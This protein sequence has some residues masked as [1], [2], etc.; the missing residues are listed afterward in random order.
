[1]KWWNQHCVSFLWFP[2]WLNSFQ[3]HLYSREGNF[4]PSW[5]LSGFGEPVLIFLCLDG[6]SCRVE[7]EANCEEELEQCNQ[8]E[9]GCLNASYSHQVSFVGGLQKW[10]W[11]KELAIFF[12]CK[13]PDMII[14]LPHVQ[15]ER[16]KI[17]ATCYIHSG[18][19]VRWSEFP[20]LKGLEHYHLILPGIRCSRSMCSL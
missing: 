11:F 18:S 9:L 16:H 5:L 10:D 15:V 6:K 4:H 12:L 7:D 8:M 1:M 2:L 17:F 13:Q 19:I 20:Q 14:I 3:T